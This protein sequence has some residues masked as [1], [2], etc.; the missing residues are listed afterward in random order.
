[1][2]DSALEPVDLRLIHALQVAPR[3]RWAALA[4]VVGADAVTL[5]RRWERLTR[6]GIA[7]VAGIPGP[8]LRGVTAMLEVQCSP[9]ATLALAEEVAGDAEAFTVDLTSGAR[10]LLVL[11]TADDMT[12]LSAYVMERMAGFP[13]IR[14]THTHLMSTVFTEAAHWRLRA[15][16][17]AEVAA[18]RRTAAVPRPGRGRIDAGLEAELLR[19]LAFD[20]RLGASVLARRLGTGER[21]VRE[22]MAAMLASGRLEIRTDMA[23]TSSG[24][25]VHAWYFLKVPAAIINQVG[26]A[27]S[28]INEIRLA[29]TAIGPYNL[30][31]SVWMRSLADVQGLEVMIEETLPGVAIS[32]RSAVLRTVKNLGHRLD[33]TGRW[34][35]QVVPVAA[36][37]APRG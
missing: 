32:D 10:D 20:G 6:A 29:V 5:A 37:R 30:V 34:T 7:W 19:E 35:G 27:L 21:R 25:P 28:R 1:M 8:P 22:G 18:V 23:K 11:V 3:A 24:R 15:L 36:V 12:A 9:A 4:P 14:S 13:A 17:G 2:Q 31:L 16:S 33:A 26:A